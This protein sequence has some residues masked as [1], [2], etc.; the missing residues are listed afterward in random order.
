[1]AHGGANPTV[2]SL[3]AALENALTP[4]V[5]RRASEVA[6]AIRGDGAAV[7]ARLLIDAIEPAAPRA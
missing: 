7:A 3:S 5:C 2:E 6:L 4:G 1:V